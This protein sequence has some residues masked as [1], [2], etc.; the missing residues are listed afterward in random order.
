MIDR[1][2]YIFVNLG[3]I[4]STGT[5]RT[6]RTCKKDNRPRAIIFACKL[7]VESVRF[8]AYVTSQGLGSDEYQPNTRLHVVDIQA[9]VAGA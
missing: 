6:N 9:R 8:V 4:L 2:Y 7:R 3:K 1:S 5:Y